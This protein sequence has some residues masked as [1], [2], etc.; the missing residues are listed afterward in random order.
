M[1]RALLESGN[2][3]VPG[4]HTVPRR[5]RMSLAVGQT[6]GYNDH[7]GIQPTLKGSNIQSVR[8]WDPDF[9]FS[10]PVGFTYDE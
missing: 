6:Y 2:V 9:R 1:A 4:F 5:G 3:A 10:V 7:G 8:G